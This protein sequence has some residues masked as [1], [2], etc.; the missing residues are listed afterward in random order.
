M[1]S[2]FFSFMLCPFTTS[3]TYLCLLQ[4]FKHIQGFYYDFPRMVWFIHESWKVK[5]QRRK[6]TGFDS[7]SC[8]TERIRLEISLRKLETSKEHLFQRWAQ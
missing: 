1:K 2:N 8:R 3:L 7:I 6:M 4:G 5:E